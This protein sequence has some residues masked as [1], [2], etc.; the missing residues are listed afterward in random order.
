MRRQQKLPLNH[1]SFGMEKMKNHIILSP[2]FLD[3]ALPGLKSLVKPDWQVNEPVL[4]DGEMQTRMSVIHKSLADYVAKTILNKERPV[5]IAGDCCAAIAVLSGLQRVGINPL[6]IWFD[7]HGD[8]NTWETTPS[9]FLGGMPLAMIV[10]KG[11]QTLPAAVGLKPQPEGKL[12]LTDARDLDS[13]ERELIKKSELTHLTNM[14]ALLDF[15]LPETPIYIHFDTDV[16]TAEE[17]PA[18]NY[19]AK[20]GP[21][22]KTVKAVFNRLARTENII[23]VSLSSWNPDL[24]QDRKSEK[25]SMSLL[26]ALIGDI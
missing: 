3:K 14:E 21:T 7:A 5:S 25:I 11:E 26:Q 24:D 15:Q 19:L 17:S 12:I 8:F 4:S 18:Q 20:G 16:V 23:G 13:G 1:Q 9:G 10:G 22:S 2:F 6:L